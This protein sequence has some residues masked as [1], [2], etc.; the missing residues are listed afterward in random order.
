M[1]PIITKLPKFFVIGVATYG[2]PQSG[3]FPKAWEMFHKQKENIEWK[4]DLKA[5]G[6]EFY[7]EEFFKEKKWFYMACME[8][9]DLASIPITM[10]GKSIPEHQYAVFSCKGGVSEIGKTFRFAYDE[11]L[12]DSSYIMADHFDFELYDKRFKGANNPETVIDLYIPI[13][14][15]E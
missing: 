6:I 12:P 7:T 9:K 3:L 8:V 1:E 11:W 14:K 13:K 4:D 10:V 5:Y 15:K 2:D